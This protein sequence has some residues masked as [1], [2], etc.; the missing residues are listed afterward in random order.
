MDSIA[1]LTSTRVLEGMFYTLNY[2]QAARQHWQHQNVNMNKLNG[3]V[4]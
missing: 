4:S 3:H 2:G 1:N